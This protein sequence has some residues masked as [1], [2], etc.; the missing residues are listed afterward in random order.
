[1]N[2]RNFLTMAASLAF[3]PQIL[4]QALPNKPI[5]MV[6]GFSAGGGTDA[7]ARLLAQKM[8]PLLDRNVVVQ[9]KPGAA[10]VIAAEHTAR[11]INDGSNL[12]MANFS[13]HSIAPSLTPSPRYDVQKD[14]TPIVL[15]GIT[16]LLLV[17]NKDQPVKTVAELVQLCK[18]DPGK[19]TFGSAGNGSAQHMALELFKL[20][21]GVDV[22]HVPYKGSGPM[23][24]DLLGGQIN[25][26]FDTM[27]S[28]GPHVASGNLVALAQSH[29]KRVE[30]FA[31]VPTM[32][33]QGFTGFDAS[34]WY[35]LVGPAGLSPQIVDEVNATV[36][37]VIAM[38]DVA[39]QLLRQGAVEGGGTPTRFADFIMAEGE[40]WA[41]V[42][43]QANVQT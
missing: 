21:A 39:A 43:K 38:P 12:L 34:T 8:G 14:F 17:G 25:F 26:S 24:T 31:D 3:A 9:N 37:K 18:Q 32:D 4:A 33:E 10:G 2:R 20:M 28:A 30:S 35:G 7:V 27:P 19:I 23:M 1:M 29:I 15:V 6:V 11:Q 40:K 5:S 16:P 13:S 41:K 22:L 36:N 42:I